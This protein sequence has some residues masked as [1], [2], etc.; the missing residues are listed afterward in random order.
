VESTSQINTN[1][2]IVKPTP[3]PIFGQ[4]ISLSYQG[5]G[6]NLVEVKIQE[7]NFGSI[8]TLTAYCNVN[9]DFYTIKIVNLNDFCFR[10]QEAFN[11][12]SSISIF[13][14]NDKIVLLEIARRVTA[15]FGGRPSRG[16]SGT[17]GSR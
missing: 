2:Q 1:L 13:Y 8:F 4:I 9:L 7:N 5:T 16:S 10:L 11:S 3:N 6:N 12:D 14:E 15:I 17:G